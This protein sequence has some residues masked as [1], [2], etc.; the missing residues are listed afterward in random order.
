MKRFLALTVCLILAFAVLPWGICADNGGRESECVVEVVWSGTTMGEICDIEVTLYRFQS[1]E[2]INDAY[3]RMWG[4]FRLEVR[5]GDGNLVMDEP[6]DTPSKELHLVD[7]G[8]YYCA[9][10]DGDG[11]LQGL[12]DGKGGYDPFIQRLIVTEPYGLNPYEDAVVTFIISCDN[13]PD[14][15]DTAFREYLCVIHNMVN[16]DEELNLNDCAEHVRESLRG[17]PDASYAAYY[18]EFLSNEGYAAMEVTPMGAYMPELMTDE[19]TFGFWKGECWRY[20][21]NETELVLQDDGTILPYAEYVE[22]YLG[23]EGLD[24]DS[25]TQSN[26]ADSKGTDSKGADSDGGESEEDAGTNT[27]VIWVIIGAAVIVCAVGVA[28]AILLCR[29]KKH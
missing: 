17:Y 21:V 9:V 10:Y 26:G 2:P 3:S 11:C 7:P 18:D 22:D 6:F 19:E 13:Y 24:G 27:A 12:S 1:S 16:Q 4:G 15:H 29:R 20:F 25:E 28:V 8:E 23:N 14:D 5:D